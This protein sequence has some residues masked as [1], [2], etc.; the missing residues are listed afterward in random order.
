M[1]KQL[2]TRTS[3][4]ESAE[5][6]EEIF[7]PGSRAAAKGQPT[8][9]PL[10]GT[11]GK[12]TP[13]RYSTQPGG[14]RRDDCPYAHPPTD[15]TAPR[16]AASAPA[17]RPAA[18]APA[19]RSAASA[20]APRVPTTRR[21]CDHGLGCHAFSC[22]FTHPPGRNAHLLMANQTP[23]RWGEKCKDWKSGACPFA[24]PDSP[25][26]VKTPCRWG[27]KCRGKKSG[28]CPFQH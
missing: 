22:P 18:S 1:H 14:C 4:T 17:P 3:S 20:P 21:A 13:C 12:K 26:G 9:Q 11:V 16:P 2:V 10:P 28:A 5:S 15:E 6:V 25:D 23:C 8:R 19:H 27:E 24:H 7:T